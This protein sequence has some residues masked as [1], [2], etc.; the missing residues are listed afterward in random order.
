M[1]FLLLIDVKN[2]FR[3]VMRVT[4]ADFAKLY[5]IAEGETPDH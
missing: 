1:L 4:T 5:K 2:N 3:Y